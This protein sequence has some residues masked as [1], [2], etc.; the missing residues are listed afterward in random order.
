LLRAQQAGEQAVQQA[1]QQAI[2][3]AIQQAAQQAAHQ[4]VQQAA[5]QAAQAW[6][7]DLTDLSL[8]QQGDN[9]MEEDENQRFKMKT[10]RMKTKT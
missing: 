2:R 9:L 4:A 8:A 5:P 7:N 6:A 1:A 3:Q 10:R